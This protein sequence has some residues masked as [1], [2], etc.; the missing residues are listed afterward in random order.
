MRKIAIVSFKGGVGKTTSAVNVSHAL[1]LVGHRVLIVDTDGSANA[2]THLLP[3]AP[4]TSLFDLITSKAELEDVIVPAR[5][6]L[7]LIAGDSRLWGIDG[8]LNTQDDPNGVLKSSLAKVKGY[9]FIVVDC[10]PTGNRMNLNAIVYTEMVI[11]PV[12]VDYLELTGLTRIIEKLNGKP[13]MVLPTFF[14]FRL[15]RAG[16]ALQVLGEYFPGKIALPIRQDSALAQ[17]PQTHQSVL[18][19]SRSSRGAQ[20]YIELAR[21]M[22]DG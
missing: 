18:E 11:V 4:A 2:T 22:A 5:D 1:A 21:R 13:F 14:D 6:G 16:E 19:F 10:G 8:F 7:D 3:E 12:G 15:K 20:D 9:E 17:A